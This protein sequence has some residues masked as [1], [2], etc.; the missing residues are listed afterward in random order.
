MLTK[1]SD[2]PVLPFHPRDMEGAAPQ[3][4][5][6]TASSSR[7]PG[8]LLKELRSLSIPPPSSNQEGL[9]S[10]SSAVLHIPKKL[11][12]TREIS[13]PFSKVSFRLPVP[14]YPSVPRPRTK[15]LHVSGYI[16]TLVV[17]ESLALT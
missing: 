16:R 11:Q 1:Q 15:A 2:G 17:A 3:A 7:G 8:L 5:P 9:N 14:S 12:P 10:D 6:S 13:A 4:L